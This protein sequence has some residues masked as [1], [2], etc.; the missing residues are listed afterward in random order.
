MADLLRQAGD[1][2]KAHPFATLAATHA[3]TGAATVWVL[4]EGKP[5]KWATKKLF[6]VAMAAVP[7]GIVEGEQAKLRKNIAK[8]VIGHALDGE[9]LYTKLPAQGA[10]PRGGVPAHT[11]TPRSPVAR[12]RR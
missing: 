3:V 11:Y 2:V 5:L 4:S 7:A 8:S 10:C 6:Q 1:F 9:T 12:A